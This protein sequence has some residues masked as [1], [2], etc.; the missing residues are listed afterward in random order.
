MKQFEKA[1]SITTN[2]F[3]TP[4]YLMKAGILHQ[5]AGNWDDARKAF[6]RIVKD[7]PNSPETMQARKYAGHAEA[8][9]G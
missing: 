5:Q 9:G 7:F 4:M 3:T 1:A 2:D 8:M 6:E